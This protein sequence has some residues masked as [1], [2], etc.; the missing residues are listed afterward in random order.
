M[1][2]TPVTQ[3]SSPLSEQDV[4]LWNEGTHFRAYQALGAHPGSRG[5]E[6]GTWFA[7]W[8]PNAERVSVIGDWNGWSKETDPMTL[9]GSSGIWEAFVPGVG[10]GARYKLHV[11]S[12]YHGYRVD[13][14]DPFA[15]R[16]EVAP[17]RASVVWSLDYAWQDAAWMAARKERQSPSAPISIYEVHLGSWRRVPEEGNRSLSYREIA[18]ALARHV[19]QLGFTH[20]ELLPVTEH[21]YF[22]SWGYQTTGYFAATSRYGTPQDLMHLI[23]R[24]HQ[25]EIGVI[26]DWVPSHFP[27]DEHG[28][29]YFDGTHLYE[30]ADPRKGYHPDWQSYI[31]N[32]D[33]NEVRCF[34]GSSALFWL[35]KY[36]AD[37][38]RVDAVAS[39]LYLDYSRKAG[40]WIPNRY[41]G[42]ENLG[43]IA[44]LR[45]VN[46]AVYASF[47]DVQTI[48]EESTSW[49]LVSRPVHL[50]GLGFG[51][52]WDM[53]WMH[54]TLR[55]LGFDPIHRRFHHNSIT[56]R[57]LYAASES[58]VLP[59]SHDEVVHGKGSL[60]AKMPGDFWQQRANLRLLYGNMVAQPGKKLLFMGAE[61]AQRKEWNH[62]ASL[63]WHL[64]DDEAHA[65]IGRWLTDLNRLYRGEPALHE[66][67]CA[68][69]GYE[70]I[71]GSDFDHSVIS[72]LRHPKAGEP[73]LVVFNYTPVP[74]HGYRIGVPAAGFWEELL[75]SDRA[76][77]G[78]SGV[79]NDGGREA[80]EV[81]AHG[82]EW[83]LALTLPPL[84]V[85]FMKR[86]A[87]SRPSPS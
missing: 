22:A 59:L 30:H 66:G 53:G 29:A 3:R 28:L 51:F 2:V 13:K 12:R 5:G 62:D 55:Y 72:F 63:D 9:R 27:S 60:L 85:V 1:S 24:L 61:L 80:E 49:P 23:D 42:R 18:P 83:S 52:K 56:F 16:A 69:A 20:V 76:E 77:Y 39:M 64:A 40:E 14:A 15:F 43:A 73:V 84:A 26:L 10:K 71:D 21:P 25:E 81:P 44:F 32:Y 17:A 33:R 19:K 86:R 37:G 47:P 36:H 6:A 45:A 35:D 41:G 38:L 67:D 79:G 7:V 8:A 54:D 34:L 75:N 4:Y 57:S 31:F 46:K 65:G 78:G 48:A 74:R 82:R 70:W 68:P 50:D 11:V 87:P 58:F